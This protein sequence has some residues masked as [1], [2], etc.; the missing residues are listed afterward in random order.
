MDS[1]S[2][3]NLTAESIV[4]T[5]IP[6]VFCFS[7]PILTQLLTKSPTYFYEPTSTAFLGRFF[8]RLT[9]L[10]TQNRFAHVHRLTNWVVIT[11]QSQ[12]K[13]SQTQLFEAT[14][15][16][17]CRLL[18][19]GNHQA[20]FAPMSDR[21][22]LW[23]VKSSRDTES[24]AASAEQLMLVAGLQAGAQLS[25]NKRRFWREEGSR[26]TLLH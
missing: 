20:Q 3:R 21:N 7:L 17:T 24:L 14:R 19:T 5:V 12:V 22:Q 16:W 25:P 15:I 4:P 11:L 10:Q 2:H 23:H 18:G 8:C 6:I 9:L 1:G 26:K 13:R